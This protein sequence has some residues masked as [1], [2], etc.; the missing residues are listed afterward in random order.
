VRPARINVFDGL[1]VSTAHVDHLQDSLS[2]S[3][4]ELREAAGL[5]RIVRPF[6]VT[7]DGDDAIVVGPGLAFDGRRR[8]LAIDEPQRVEVEMPAGR[9]VQ[10]VCLEHQDVEEGEVEGKPTLIFDAVAVALRDSAPGAA[11]DQLAIAKLV[12]PSGA[13]TGFEVAPLEDPAPAPVVPVLRVAQGVVRLPRG[14]APT[15][16]L[17]GALIAPAEGELVVSLA[18]AEAEVGFAPASVGCTARLSATLGET[19]AV[20][21]SHGE[22]AV[23]GDAVTRFGFSADGVIEDG[24]AWVALLEG[25]RLVVDVRPAPPASVAV[26]CSLVCDPPFDDARIDALKAALTGLSWA[27]SVGWKALG[28]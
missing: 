18:I 5:G 4:E 25:A 13:A 16:D 21:L 9:D 23:A 1:R 27:A 19:T 11:D 26:E 12:R 6:G 20:A 22:V 17:E 28:T 10:Y 3:I 7:A 24:V 15:V 2:S 14:D 8:R